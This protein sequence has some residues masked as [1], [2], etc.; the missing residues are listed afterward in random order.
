MS[1]QTLFIQILYLFLS[2]VFTTILPAV[3]SL[4]T[5]YIQTGFENF[6]I[7]VEHNLVAGVF[8]FMFVYFAATV[9]FVPG[10]ILSLGSGFVFGSAV[11]VGP[12]VVLATVAV[13]VGASLGAIV[14]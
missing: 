1:N 6:L 7:W 8:A 14:R 11:G 5:K 12:G 4:T 10:F 13:F 2:Y 9:A 3:D